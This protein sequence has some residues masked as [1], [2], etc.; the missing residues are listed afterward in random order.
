MNYTIT[1]PSPRTY[2]VTLDTAV[3]STKY[4]ENVNKVEVFDNFITLF[5]SDG[6]VLIVSSAKLISMETAIPV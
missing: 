4:V 6:G 2:E 1:H 3:N 5:T